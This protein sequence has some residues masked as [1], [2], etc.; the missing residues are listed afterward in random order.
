LSQTWITG[1]DSSRISSLW[2]RTLDVD[3]GTV[4]ALRQHRAAQEFERRSWGDRYKADL[5]LVFCRRDG[6]AHDP[7][8]VHH[9]FDSLVKG[10]GVRGIR[11]HDLRHTYATLQRQE[12]VDIEFISRQLGHDSVQ[13]TLDL[14]GHITPKIRAAAA[15]KISAILDSRSQPM[16]ELDTDVDAGAKE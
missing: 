10:A 11:F 3:Q 1:V 6:S 16:E 13:T 12:G 8:T 5:D 14:Y 4:D 7:D 2:R 15:S 9:R